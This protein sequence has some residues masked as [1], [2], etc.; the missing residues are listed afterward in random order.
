MTKSRLLPLAL[1]L[2]L[3]LALPVSAIDSQAQTSAVN[4]HGP[5]V[6]D[7]GEIVPAAEPFASS[8]LG[9][10]YAGAGAGG[11]GQAAPVIKHA[12][13]GPLSRLALGATISAFG[14]GGEAAVN[15]SQH[16]DTRSYANYF[17]DSPTFSTNGF[18]VTAN[19][20]LASAGTS[21]D[22]YPFHNGFRLSPGILSYNQ[23]RANAV[24]LAAVGTSIT[25]NDQDYYSATP[26][27]ALGITALTGHGTVGLHQ[28]RPAFTATTGWGSLI[29]RSG[30]HWAIPFEIGAAFTGTPSINMTLTGWGCLDKAQTMCNDVADLTNPVS[31]QIQ[32]ALQAQLAKWRSDLKPLKVYPI[33]ST[34]FV[35]NFNVRRSN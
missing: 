1:V 33:I 27:A 6:G 13:T 20:H 29:P 26:N 24:A 5:A 34:G 16:L 19:I 28:T 12:S 3:P 9:A 7:T 8:A 17:Q 23:N 21:L 31:I 32:S 22:Y 15:L 11:F 10:A 35:F 30:K 4:F 2:L 18:N 14:I 25:L